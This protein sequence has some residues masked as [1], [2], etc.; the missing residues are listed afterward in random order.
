MS[1]PI[2]AF[3]VGYLAERG[4]D[5][6]YLTSVLAMLAGW[7]VVY[8]CGAMWLGLLRRS[9]QQAAPIGLAGGA[10]DGRRIRSSSPTS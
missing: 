3:L 2:A 5:R 10:R 1:Y 8:A 9:V 6:R 7:L 4:F